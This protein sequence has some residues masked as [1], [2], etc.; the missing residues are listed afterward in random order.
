[1]PFLFSPQLKHLFGVET[2]HSSTIQGIIQGLADNISGF[3]WRDCV[4]W[5]AGGAWEWGGQVEVEAL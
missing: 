2:P 3:N 1:M 4:M 5:V